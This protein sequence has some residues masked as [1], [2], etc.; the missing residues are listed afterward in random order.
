[1][2]AATPRGV[3]RTAGD[4]LAMPNNTLHTRT[5][6]GLAPP[7]RA[8]VDIVGAARVGRPWF[9]RSARDRETLTRLESPMHACIISRAAGL[10]A[11]LAFTAGA[12]R[13]DRA[14]IQLLRLE[15]SDVSRA[16]AFYSA[17]F[18]WGA[19]RP[20]SALAILD[21]KPA[22]IALTRRDT[23]RTMIPAIVVSV[24]DLERV[25]ARIVERG[26]VI[27]API[28]PSWRGREFRFADPDENELIVWSDGPPPRDST[29]A[30]ADGVG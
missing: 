20:D 12:C 18:E 11:L 2:E 23:V 7:F 16:A 26:G 1:M 15:V 21:S 27:G 17:V 14:Q 10:L 4:A 3:A 5:F 6:W 22:A 19:S 29:A 28:G 24:S 13:E 25:H 9:T 8:T 30:G